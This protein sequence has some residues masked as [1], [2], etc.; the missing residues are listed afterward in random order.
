MSPSTPHPCRVSDGLRN[1]VW[2]SLLDGEMNDRYWRYRSAAYASREKALKIFLAITSSGTVAG[3]VVW[4]SIPLLWQL[5]SGVSALL[6]IAL[7]ILDYTGQVERAS[8]LREGWWDLTAEYDRLWAGIDSSSDALV[9][10]QTKP[11]KAKEGE[12]SKTESK[13]FSR[14]E[15]LILK[16]QHEVLRARSLPVAK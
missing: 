9:Q 3:W 8:D 6:A 15:A 4:H 12:M 11:L 7:P 5:L 13:Y 16:C 10:E 14:D 2:R 1:Y